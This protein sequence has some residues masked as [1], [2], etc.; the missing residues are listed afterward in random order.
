MSHK[1][2]IF[3][4]GASLTLKKKKLYHYIKES[5]FSRT[6]N[7]GQI[8][9]E[10]VFD[11]NILPLFSN[12]TTESLYEPKTTFSRDTGVVGDFHITIRVYLGE[13][14]FRGRLVSF[15][16]SSTT[17]THPESQGL[18]RSFSKRRS[19]LQFW[20]LTTYTYILREQFFYLSYGQPH[21]STLVPVLA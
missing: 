9:G 19:F 20:S 4:K 12:W 10:V 17:Y 13:A 18:P 8:K 7:K 5:S 14:C 11:S 1:Y 15:L 6:G 21:L 3:G 2:F 16:R